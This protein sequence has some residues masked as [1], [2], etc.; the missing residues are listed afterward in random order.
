MFLFN[1]QSDEKHIERVES[2]A[3]AVALAAGQVPQIIFSFYFQF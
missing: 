3:E 2:L 1:I